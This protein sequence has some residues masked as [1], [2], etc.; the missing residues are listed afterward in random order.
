VGA[1]RPAGERNGVGQGK[2]IR[3]VLVDDHR[4]VRDGLEMLLAREPGIEIV[5]SCASGWAAVSLCERTAPDVVVMDLSM[6]DMDGTRATRMIRQ[7][8]PCTQVLV[9]T[10]FLEEALLRASLDA[11]A[12]GYLLKSVSRDGLV[13]AVRAAA[14]GRPTVDPAALA[15]LLRPGPRR[16]GNDLTG[17]ERDVLALLVLGKTNQEIGLDLGISP[18]TVRVYVSNILLK[19]DVANRTEAAVAAVQHGLVAAAESLPHSASV[20]R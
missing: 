12:C 9:L 18:G 8:R 14:L 17:R 1:G 6:P 15:L 19:L 10:S 5:G 20:L 13:A 7:R 11:G 16:P 2:K 4:V 3:L